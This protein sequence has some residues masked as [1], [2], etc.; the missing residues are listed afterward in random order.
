MRRQFLIFADL[1]EAC[2]EQHHPWLQHL[3][4]AQHAL[5]NSYVTT[6][7]GTSSGETVVDDTFIEH[8][9]CS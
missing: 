7:G 9:N 4:S 2:P 5:S 1:I 6:F 3:I 8:E